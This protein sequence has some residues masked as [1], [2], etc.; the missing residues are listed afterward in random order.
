MGGRAQPLL[1]RGRESR[2]FR[3]VF[4]AVPTLEDEINMRLLMRAT[5][6]WLGE[7]D[8]EPVPLRGNAV[9]LR[10]ATAAG[11][12]AAWRA[13]CP[14]VGIV[15]IPGDHDSLFDPEYFPALQSAFARA[16]RRWG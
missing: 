16:T 9:L 6:P 2:M 1:R 3:A 10:T 4:A 11:S 7:I 15:E 12:D 13:R 5:A 8:R 14:D